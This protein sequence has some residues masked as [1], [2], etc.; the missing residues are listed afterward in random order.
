MGELP[1]KLFIKENAEVIAIDIN[2]KVL[3]TLQ[4]ATLKTVDILDTKAIDA[5]VDEIGAIDVLFNCAGFV[6]QGSI[7][8]CEPKDLEFSWQLNVNAMYKMIQAFLPKMLASKK[9]ASI[10]NMA[11]VASSILGG[12]QSICLCDD[13]GG[14]RR[15]DQIDRC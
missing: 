11:S 7:L 13:K 3:S 10:I 14:R 9:G 4:G 15:F 8:E 5:L 12:I 6:H 1:Q 2:E